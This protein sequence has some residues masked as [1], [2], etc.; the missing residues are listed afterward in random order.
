VLRRR[1]A[2]AVLLGLAVAAPVPAYAL[3]SGQAPAADHLS[4]EEARSFSKEIERELASRG[5]VVAMVFRTGRPREKLPEGTSYTH[6][7]FWVYQSSVTPDGDIV[8]GYAV[9]NLYT[10][11]GEELPVT[12]SRLVQDYPFDFTAAS[13]EDDV[14]VII[15]TREVQRRLLGVI[16]SPD[17]AALHVPEYSLVSNPADARYQNCNEF[18]LD[19]LASGLWETADYTQIKV[20]LAASFKPARIKAGGLK[21]LFAPLADSRLRLGD[22]GRVIETVTF[23]SLSQFM[24]DYGYAGEILRVDLGAGASAFTLP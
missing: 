7:A 20:N 12:R 21:R 18:M 23:E 6:G 10:G 24:Q 3:D 15:P 8:K 11:D 13:H 22:Q 2:A 16:A 1:L 4:A 17:Y 19:V 5:T 9:Y 14:A